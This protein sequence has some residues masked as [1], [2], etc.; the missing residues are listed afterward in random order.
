MCKRKS[1]RIQSE[2]Q[3]KKHHLKKRYIFTWGSVNIILSLLINIGVVIS[4][5]E[6]SRVGITVTVAIGIILAIIIN[7]A[8]DKYYEKKYRCKGEE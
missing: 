6:K 5:L 4:F 2:G 7:L 3:Q 1:K 8:A